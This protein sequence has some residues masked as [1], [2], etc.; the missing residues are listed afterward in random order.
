MRIIID[1]T[2]SLDAIIRSFKHHPSIIK[3]KQHPENITTFNFRHVS[4]NETRAQI[5]SLD[6]SKSTGPG[7]IPAKILKLAISEIEQ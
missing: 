3:I 1:D 7:Q 5:K 6:V 4:V 2:N